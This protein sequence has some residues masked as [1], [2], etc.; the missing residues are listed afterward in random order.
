MANASVALPPAV[1]TTHRHQHLIQTWW[2]SGHH[3]HRPERL[4]GV[5]IGSRGATIDLS[6]ESGGFQVALPDTNGHLLQPVERAWNPYWDISLMLLRQPGLCKYPKACNTCWGGFRTFLT[7]LFVFQ[8]PVSTILN[9]V[10][11]P[12]VQCQQITV[13]GKHL[14][15]LKGYHTHTHTHPQSQTHTHL[16]TFS[17]VRTFT[18]MVYSPAPYPYITTKPLTLTLALS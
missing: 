18:D 3:G 11:P 15:I 7:P 4:C 16:C 1:I 14:I 10:A 5:M 12:S 17:F 2:Q 9:V 8:F 13:S 6:S